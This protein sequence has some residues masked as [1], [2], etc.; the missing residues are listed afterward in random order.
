MDEAVA[1][2]TE[3]AGM[4]EDS[5]DT[6]PQSGHGEAELSESEMEDEEAEDEEDGEDWEDEEDMDRSM[7][8]EPD[9][10]IF[11]LVRQGD[12][13]GVRK[14]LRS[15]LTAVKQQGGMQHTPLHCSSSMGGRDEDESPA[16]DMARLLLSY[17]APV[18][19]RASDFDTPLHIACFDGRVKMC[20]LL[21]TNG[22]RYDLLQDTMDTRRETPLQS[23]QYSINDIARNVGVG[24]VKTLIR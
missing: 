11:D 19:S 5:E 23:A 8:S 4:P 6:G 18:N 7:E 24:L 22:A 15:D 20:N 1:R 3:E 10:I 13:A 14:I 9:P 12:M 17:G 2:E 16:L 21:L